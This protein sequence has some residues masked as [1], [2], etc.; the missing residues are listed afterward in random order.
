M[1]CHPSDGFQLARFGEEAI[2]A[3]GCLSVSE[4]EKLVKEAH[5]VHRGERWRVIRSMQKYPLF[6][7][8][9]LWELYTLSYFFYKVEL[10]KGDVIGKS[11]AQVAGAD[12]NR[13]F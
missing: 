4:C 13:I 6:Q 5:G 7:H 10:K 1:T 9:T 8:C 12:Q 2:A 11:T 3:A